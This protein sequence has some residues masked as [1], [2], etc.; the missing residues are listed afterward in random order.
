MRKRIV[1]III[2][3]TCSILISI[4]I[5]NYQVDEKRIYIE[6]L[7]GSRAV[8]GMMIT[9]IIT[10]KG[11]PEKQYLSQYTFWDSDDDGSNELH[12]RSERYYYI[13]DSI[14]D[15]LY[16]WKSLHPRTELL[17]NGD[18]LYTHIGEGP[19]HYDYKYFK[20]NQEGEESFSISYS[21]YDNNS[22]NEFDEKDL[23]I[24]ENKDIISYEEWKQVQKNYLDVGTD[25]ILWSV[26]TEKR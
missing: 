6:F 13:I 25:M 20:I 17:N 5:Y 7:S 23:Y 19:L 8:N 4:L 14:N 24:R 9:D 16:V 10:P 12:I 21:W 22:N 26:L 11:E 3:F 1:A 18:Y 15:E 2:C